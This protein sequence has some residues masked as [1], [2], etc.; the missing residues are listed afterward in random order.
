[1]V[2]RRAKQAGLKN[3][4][5]HTLRHYTATEMLRRGA[6]TSIVQKVMGHANIST[7]QRYTHITDRDVAEI[8]SAVMG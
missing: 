8:Y 4:S 1:M 7:T 6:N 3:I 2:H 5:P